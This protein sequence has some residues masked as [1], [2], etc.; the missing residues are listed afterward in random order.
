MK[1]FIFIAA[2]TAF[3]GCSNNASEQTTASDSSSSTETNRNVSAPVQE[4]ETSAPKAD[5]PTKKDNVEV[6][7][8]PKD[9][10]RT[11]IS[12]GKSGA[13]VKTK[14]GTGVSVDDKGVRIG[15]KDVKIDVKKDTL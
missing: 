8:V 10:P 9:T 4:K 6:K 15:T 3:I 14:S 2:M 7:E 13:E 11:S 5:V 12:V 1:S